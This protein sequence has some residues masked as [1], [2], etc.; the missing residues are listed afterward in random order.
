MD[1]EARTDDWQMADDPTPDEDYVPPARL[2]AAMSAAGKKKAGLSASDM[3]LRGFMS[4]MVLGF[5]TAVSLTAVAEGSPPWVGALLFPLGFV[6]LVLLGH[7]LVTGNFA[8]V[9]VAAF[10]G[11]VTTPRVLRSWGLVFVGNLLGSVA[12]AALLYAGV[13]KFG[14]GGGGALGDVIVAKAEG[15]TLAYA[16]AGAVVGV[17]TAFVKAILCNWMVATGTVMGLVSTRVVGKIV[18]M[19]LP[20]FA[21][22]AMGF[23]HSV[24]NM[25]LI[26]AGML[27]GAKIT[28]ADWWVWNQVTVTVGNIVGALLLVGWVLHRTHGAR[29]A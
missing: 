29:R 9:P 19:W 25:F 22:F 5:A 20:I 26:P 24:V 16:K 18:A 23:E 27:F 12:F 13:T 3:V 4:G 1:G 28:V 7:E 6:I 21:F 8:V 2:V 11:H 15:K 14:H 17:G 10:D